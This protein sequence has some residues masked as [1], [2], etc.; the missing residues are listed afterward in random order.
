MFTI[1]VLNQKGGCGK[2]TLSQCMAA[3]AYAAGHRVAVLDL[4]EQGASHGIFRDEV[5]PGRFKKEDFFVASFNGRDA[6]LKSYRDLCQIFSDQGY[7]F[8]ILDLP[9]KLVSQEHIVS[10]ITDMTLV[11]M[12]ISNQDLK[13]TIKTVDVLNA[14]GVTSLVI[15]SRVPTS[16]SDKKYP[17]YREVLKNLTAH[18]GAAVSSVEITDRAEYVDVGDGLFP[19]LDAP[20]TAAGKETVKLFALIHEMLKRLN[21]LKAA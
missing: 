16:K 18:E 15:P 12:F 21:Q 8:L 13:S 3:A 10:T 9:P 11:P 4:D 1:T 17:K 20:K 19:P 14:A 7:E 5:Q 2:T 6:D